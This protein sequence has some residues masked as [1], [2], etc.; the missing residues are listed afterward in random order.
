MMEVF[1]KRLESLLLS[2]KLPTIVQPDLSPGVS[3]STKGSYSVVAEMVGYIGFGSQCEFY[4]LVDYV[5]PF[6]LLAH[7]KCFAGS[8]MLHGECLHAHLVKVMVEIVCYGD[9]VVFTL[10]S[11]AGI[12]S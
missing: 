9:V 10:T 2:Q 1:D 4:T 8:T 7:G 5:F 3:V 12:V 11:K 6:Q